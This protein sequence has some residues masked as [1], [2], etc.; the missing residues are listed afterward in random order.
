MNR[1]IALLLLLSFTGAF[2]T[3]FAQRKKAAELKPTD[4]VHVVAGPVSKGKIFTYKGYVG[5][6]ENEYLV[7]R[8]QGRKV[9]L[10]NLNSSLENVSTFRTD[11]EFPFEERK[12][13]FDHVIKMA[14]G[15][16]HYLYVARNYKERTQTLV[17]YE[18]KISNPE[19]RLSEP[20]ALA[21]EHWRSDFSYQK[22]P[23]EKYLLIY[24]EASS[25]QVANETIS[26]RVFN[27]K[28]ELQW[29]KTIELPYPADRFVS[30]QLQV[31]NHGNVYVT[32]KEY[33][34]KRESRKKPN[35][36]Y[37]VIAYLNQGNEIRDYEVNLQGKF[38]NDMQVSL[39]ENGDIVGAGFY[40]DVSG[41]QIKGSFFLSIDGQTKQIVKNSMLPFSFE[42]VTEGYSD[43]KKKRAIKK[44]EKKARKGEED[45]G[46]ELAEFEFRE[47]IM[48]E[49]GGA[50]VL[51]EQYFIR[52]HTRYDAQSKSYSTYFTY[53]YRDIIVVN[54]NPDGTVAWNCRIPKNQNGGNSHYFSYTSMVYGDKIY[55]LFN[56]HPNNLAPNV[57]KE[58]T[59]YTSSYKRENHLA[60]VEIS[61][62]GSFTKELLLKTP[63][64]SPIPVMW[65]SLQTKDNEILLFSDNR[66]KFQFHRIV[67]P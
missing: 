47:L 54:I 57:E 64:K 55:L 31:D 29:E 7:S 36:K 23:D 18:S 60:L 40:S 5:S 6:S 32:G 13:R 19:T 28:M 16:L 12:A 52:S 41:S 37:H 59:S 24:S 10:E 45:S 34:E 62:D 21:R 8:W 35:Y 3:G 9:L 17:H 51:A 43:G 42:F 26:L 25:R 11:Y 61:S 56:D 38:I 33:S 65:K 1:T 4:K 67:F 63:K 50:L 27:E 2:Q 30:Q 58:R 48:R 14:D 15:H 49:D 22:S 53:H 44:K 39:T 46:P 20:V 66:K